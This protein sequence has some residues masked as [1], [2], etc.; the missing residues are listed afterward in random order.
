MHRDVLTGWALISRA[1]YFE[2]VHVNFVS[3][4]IINFSFSY[5]VSADDVSL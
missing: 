5:G 4:S 2:A 3:A 1:K